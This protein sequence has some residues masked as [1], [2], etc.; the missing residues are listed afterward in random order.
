MGLGPTLFEWRPGAHRN[1]EVFVD[2]SV[3]AA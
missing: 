3:P 1:I 2:T